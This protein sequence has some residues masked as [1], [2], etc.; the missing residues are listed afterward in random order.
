M[1]WLLPILLLAAAAFAVP[2]YFN[3]V[4]EVDELFDKVLREIA[5]AL[6]NSDGMPAAEEARRRHAPALPHL[7]LISQ[8]WDRGGHLRYRSHRF[9]P[10]PYEP[11]EGWA[12]SRW[13]GQLWRVFTLK[14]PDGLIQVAQSQA[15]RRDTAIE[16]ALHLLTPLLVLLPGLA[17][18][19]WFGLGRA[20]SPLQAIASAVERRSPDS[21]QPIPD[22][23]LPREVCALVT[24]LNRLLQ[25]LDEA[26]AAQRRFIAD[27]AHELR[28]P[29][30]A[31]SLQA[32]VA[33]RATLPEKRHGAFQSLRLG[34]ARASHLL[35]QLLALARLDPEAGAQ[36]PA[37]LRLDELARAT[38]AD[39]LPLVDA[40]GI[41]LGIRAADPAVIVGEQDSLRILLA[42]LIDNAVR[43]TPAGGRVDVSVIEDAAAVRLEVSDNGPGIPFKERARVF[44][45]FYRVLGNTAPGSGL[46]LAI[47][48]RIADRHGA[49][50]RLEDGEAG[51]GLKVAIHFPAQ[52]T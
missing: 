10:L 47:V 11:V 36:P 42:N 2:T 18:L 20:L 1:A 21:L 16:E 9:A 38:V 27:A 4:E 6:Q 14:T 44:D 8:V 12:T 15:E 30:A 19:V 3:V 28:T 39:F 31:L 49:T 41:D 40:R 34:I 51:L 23:G 13:N 35:E 45:R 5:Y 52:R 24:A 33:E 50:I 43:Y 32:Q 29:L 25:R 17:L 48:K 37:A 7:D 22:Q 26:L 46:G